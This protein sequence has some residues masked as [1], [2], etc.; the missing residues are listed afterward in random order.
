MKIIPEWVKDLARAGWT[1]DLAKRNWTDQDFETL[2]PDTVIRSAETDRW[3]HG[4]TPDPETDEAYAAKVGEAY[5]V[6][7]G[8]LD[9]K[10]R[11][12]DDDRP[13]HPSALYSSLDPKLWAE[14]FL[15]HHPHIIKGLDTETMA[16]WFDYA[17]RTGQK[18][19]KE[20]STPTAS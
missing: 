11:Q 3:P 1:E 18:Y 13:I 14:T 20:N 6:Q 19:G 10:F 16:A 17:L 12:T 4:I 15:G 2:K 9:E 5:T 7:M 8:K